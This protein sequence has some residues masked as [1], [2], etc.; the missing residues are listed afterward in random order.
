MKNRFILISFFSIV[1]SVL[2]FSILTA[3]QFN[4]D[5]TELSITENGNKFKGLK[6]EL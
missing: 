5:V 2:N 6:K 1:F 3:E 4:F